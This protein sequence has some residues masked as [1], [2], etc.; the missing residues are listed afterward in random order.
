MIDIKNVG[1]VS[2]TIDKWLEEVE[3][4]ATK[5]CR[6]VTV[7]IFEQILVNSVQYSGDFAGNW[8]YELNSITPE[9]KPGVAFTELEKTRVTW[10][11]GKGDE[12]SGFFSA[13]MG[14]DEGGGDPG[15]AVGYSLRSARGKDNAFKLGDTVYLHNS[16]VHDDAYAPGIETGTTKLR[17]KQNYAPVERAYEAILNHVAGGASSVAGGDRLV[18]FDGYKKA[19]KKT[20]LDS[21][22]RR[23]RSNSSVLGA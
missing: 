3:K 16:S 17:V 6:G 19:I 11:Q 12:K 23:Q 2:A 13:F 1:E 18:G 9:F 10:T 14:I 21:L 5:F 7:Q 8:K 22:R 4:M 15:V 20:Q